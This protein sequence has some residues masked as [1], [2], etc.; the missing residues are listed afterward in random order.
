MLERG[1]NRWQ[2]FFLRLN[3]IEARDQDPERVILARLLRRYLQPDSPRWIVLH[4]RGE[5]E[6]GPA[7]RRCA[8]R[9][10][11]SQLLVACT[12]CLEAAHHECWRREGGCPQP[13]C[14]EERQRISARAG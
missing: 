13:L 11:T 3:Q 8:E 2:T 9:L 7:C 6:V 10:V 12:V 5:P 4:P 14:A 1:E